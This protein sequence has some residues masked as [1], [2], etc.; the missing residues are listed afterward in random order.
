MHLAKGQ[1]CSRVI[2]NSSLGQSRT[3]NPPPKPQT[4]PDSFQNLEPES[5]NS[6]SPK[7]YNC[8]PHILHYP[9]IP[10]RK[11]PETQGGNKLHLQN[12]RTSKAKQSQPNSN[13][14][15][16]RVYKKPAG[17]CW[18]PGTARFC[19]PAVAW[20]KVSV[21]ELSRGFRV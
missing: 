17:L 13:L 19:E 1:R 9:F 14:E 6:S 11:T 16:F 4:Q 10:E 7:A 8:K 21:L 2:F 12:K 20:R 15:P 18:G 5:L 3:C